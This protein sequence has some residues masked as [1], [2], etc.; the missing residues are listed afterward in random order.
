[1][2]TGHAVEFTA[3]AH[4]LDA[5]DDDDDDLYSFGSKPLFH[6]PS[7]AGALYRPSPTVCLLC[8]YGCVGTRNDRLDESCPTGEILVVMTNMLHMTNGLR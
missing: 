5:L 2:C 8:G 1:M 7:G 3:T 4:R 6:N